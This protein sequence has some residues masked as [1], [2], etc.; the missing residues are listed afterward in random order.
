LRAI[1]LTGVALTAM[2][3]AA[4]GYEAFGWYSLG[5]ATPTWSVVATALAMFSGV[6]LFAVGI[7]GEYVGRIFEE[8]KGRPL[9][10]VKREFGTG[11]ALTSHRA[12][13]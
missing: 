7:V 4:A 8:A 6:Q 3:I 11:L 12:Q 10:V 2:A 13:A 5:S 9:F 1:S